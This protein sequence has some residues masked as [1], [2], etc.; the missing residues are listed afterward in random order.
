VAKIYTL[1]DKWDKFG[2]MFNKD[3]RSRAS[4]LAGG[5][6]GKRRPDAQ[7]GQKVAMDWRPLECAARAARFRR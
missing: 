4:R 1:R 7:A 2:D 5:R 3:G 6:G